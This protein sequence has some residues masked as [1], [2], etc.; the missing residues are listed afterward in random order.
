MAKKKIIS[1]G[2]DIPGVDLERINF[3]SKTSLLDFDISIIN[4]DISNFYGYGDDDYLGKPSLNDSNSFSLKEHLEHWRREIRE[5]IRAGKNIFLMLNK[6]QTVYVATGTK[7]HSGTGRNRQTTRHVTSSSNYHL[8]P[9][10]I[11]VV[12]NSNGTSMTLTGKENV[13]APY[14]SAMCDLSEFRVL[15]ECED[16]KPIVQTK[17]GQK[18]VGGIL[19]YKNS[20]G[21]LFLLPYIDFELDK[22]TYSKEEE[23][24]DYKTYWTNEAIALG[25]KFITSICALDKVLKSTGELSAMPDWLTQDKYILPKEEQ[26]RSKLIEVDKKLDDLQ[27]Q[28]EQLEQELADESTLKRLLYENGKALEDSI[29]VALELMGF[30]V[31]HFK[32]SESEFDVVFESKEG[33]IIGEAEGKDNKAINVDKL[34][35]LE[36]NIHE[37]FARDEVKDIAKGALIGNAYR[38]SEPG[39]RSNFFTAKCLSAAN[40]SSTALISS[41][42]LFY[43]AK[44]LSAKSDKAFSKNCR[45]AILKATG[46]VEFPEIPITGKSNASIIEETKDA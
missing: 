34:R 27:T 35:Q 46:V 39:E 20:N 38:L 37:D 19:R 3:K 33:R 8:V 6:E 16:L 29:R 1:I 41:V 32:E 15:L 44:Y 7:S 22:Y 21:Y 10:Q 17:T 2:F 45:T 28:K 9:G 40:R 26:V 43:V 23:E 11:M 12:T 24:E 31:S 36:M 30:N 25:K 13:L 14:W 42:D 18:T 4:P 5:G